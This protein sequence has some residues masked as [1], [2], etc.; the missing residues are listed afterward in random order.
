M[1]SCFGLFNKYIHRNRTVFSFLQKTHRFKKKEVTISPYRFVLYLHPENS[2]G[3]CSGICL[4][5][6][7]YVT[8][9]VIGG[10]GYTSISLDDVIAN[11]NTMT[12]INWG[13][14]LVSAVFDAFSHNL[15]NCCRRRVCYQCET[16]F[17]NNTNIYFIFYWVNVYG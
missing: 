4:T 6:N 13:F 10:G 12:T 1:T 17:A 15:D 8:V 3:R 7:T 11:F 14:L 16:V 2:N 9:L 5:G